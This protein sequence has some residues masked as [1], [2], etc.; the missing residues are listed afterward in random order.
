MV[1]GKKKLR[2]QIYPDTCE[3]GLSK[4]G[5]GNSNKNVAKQKV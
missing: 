5:D 4:S 1:A 3:R 2:I